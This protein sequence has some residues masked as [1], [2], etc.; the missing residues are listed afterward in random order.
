MFR[1]KELLLIRTRVIDA[2]PELRERE[3]IKMDAIYDALASALRDRGADETTAR[4][5]T[6]M[7]ISIWRVASERCLH[8]DDD[9][10]FAAEVRDAARHLRRIAAGAT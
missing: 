4:I 3:L 8:G 6:D 2:N 1:P 5:A 9:S 10:S 7:A